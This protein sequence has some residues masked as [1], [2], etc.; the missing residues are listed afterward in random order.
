M[1]IHIYIH[2]YIYIYIHICIYVY[3]YVRCQGSA[4]GRPQAARSHLRLRQAGYNQ[5]NQ[6]VCKLIL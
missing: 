1:Y 6:S 2:I 3:M 5:Y 4:R